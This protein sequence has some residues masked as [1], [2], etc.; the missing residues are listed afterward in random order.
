MFVHFDCF[1]V[2]FTSLIL[3][4]HLVGQLDLIQLIL[5]VVEEER[6]QTLRISEVDPLEKVKGADVL[7]FAEVLH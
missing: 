3:F 5:K 2:K 6:L 4:C 1:R 7:F